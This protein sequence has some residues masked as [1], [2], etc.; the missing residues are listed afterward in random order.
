MNYTDTNDPKF[1]EL[2]V[3]DQVIAIRG[4]DLIPNAPAPG[5]R[6]FVVALGKDYDALIPEENVQVEFFGFEGRFDFNKRYLQ[7]IS[8]SQP[9]AADYYA[10]STEKA[11]EW[12][13]KRGYQYHGST[14]A[15]LMDR[16]VVGWPVGPI[17]ELEDILTDYMGDLDA[18]FDPTECEVSM[19]WQIEH[20]KGV[21]EAYKSNLDHLR[22]CGAVEVAVENP[23]VAEYMKHWE[24]RT[25]NAES[26]AEIQKVI[27]NVYS[28]KIDEQDKRI[29]QLESWLNEAATALGNCDLDSV[30]SVIKKLKDAFQAALNIP[31]KKEYIFIKEDPEVERAWKRSCFG[32]QAE[33]WEK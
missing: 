13:F 30:A 25:E 15:M 11:R 12:L 29:K 17:V 5:D 1:S 8:N 22:N 27:S 7:K 9:V 20:L 31:T 6:G 14:T 33:D 4:Y 19:R 21:V 26:D 3:G 2:K 28:Q 32:E 23:S 24:E 10:R 16:T 18:D